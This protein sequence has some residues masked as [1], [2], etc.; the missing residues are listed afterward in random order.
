NS[1]QAKEVLSKHL[2]TV[3][4]EQQKLVDAGKVIPAKQNEIPHLERLLKNPEVF[5]HPLLHG[6][7][8]A[9]A[10]VARKVAQ[11][12]PGI[13]DLQA[14]ERRLKPQTELLGITRH[15]GEAQTD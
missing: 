8:R 2:E 5:D 6:A 3:R 12:S 13:A 1:T 10:T 11:E 15:E 7:V 9:G 14:V 4:A